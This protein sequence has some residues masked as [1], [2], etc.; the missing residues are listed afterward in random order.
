VAVLQHL[1][2]PVFLR[3]GG[4]DQLAAA[5]RQVPHSRCGRGGAAE[6]NS[7]SPSRDATEGPPPGI[8]VVGLV[9]LARLPFLRIGQSHPHLALPHMEHRLPSPTS[10]SSAL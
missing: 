8:L 9:P 7:A 3:A 5:P 1:A 4:L 10:S 6:S 2:H